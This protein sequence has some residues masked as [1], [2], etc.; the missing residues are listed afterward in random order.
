MDMNHEVIMKINCLGA[1]S[2]NTG[3]TDSGEATE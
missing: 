1:S 3:D 2:S